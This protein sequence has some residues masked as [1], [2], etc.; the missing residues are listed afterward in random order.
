[1]FRLKKHLDFDNVYCLGSCDDNVEEMLKI[2]DRKFGDPCKI[3][4]A[5]VPEIRCFKPTNSEQKH[6]IIKFIN[7]EQKHIII[8]FIN[9]EQKHI[10]IKFE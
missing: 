2:L 7:S 5:V 9:P 1:M 6:I 10:I 4:D 8:K 3:T